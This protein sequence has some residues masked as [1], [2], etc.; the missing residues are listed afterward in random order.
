MKRLIITL[1]TTMILTGILTGPAATVHAA[2]EP[3]EIL[4][5]AGILIDA[6][7]GAVLYSKNADYQLEPASTTKMITCLLA[8]ENLQL[9]QV[10]TIDAETPFTEGSRIYL[11]EGE[12]IT[13]EHLLYALMLESA[14]DAAVALA[15]E[16]AGSVENFAVMMN[17]RAKE[18]GA[19]N[20]NFVNPNGLHLEG[21]ASTVYDLAMIAK[22]AME[23]E[24][25][26]TIVSTYRHVIP[27]TNK[28]EERYMYNTNRLLYDE[29]TK[30][31]VLGVNRPAKYEGA[32]GI[33]T[34]YTSHAQGCLVAGAQ[35]EG[36][37]LIAAVLQ[38]TDPGRFGDCIALLDYGFANFRTVQPV[39]A[40]TD[41]GEVSV[42]K[43]AVKTV[44]TIIADNGYVTLPP[45]ASESV[46]KTEIK[47]DEDIQAPITAGQKLGV[48][49]IYEGGELYGSV[50][51][52]ATGSVEAGGF[53]ILTSL[54]VADKTAGTILIVSSIVLGLV[55]LLLITYIILK[56]R[57]I[58]RRRAR[59]EKR[60]MEIA[61]E[62]QKRQKE[63]EQ[64]QW[65]YLR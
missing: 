25:F 4:A 37:E 45:E 8:L 31:P 55:L 23:N 46:I 57:Q 64:R 40:G 29:K 17:E 59:R 20:T 19:K 34:G 14:I 26:R 58:R 15:K 63:Y 22:G 62:R 7:T 48:V 61:L 10:V 51:I 2:A 13:V 16:I 44:G 33:K 5:T 24:T 6:K 32:I 65:P 49:E 27:A 11:L 21:H 52:I 30:V 54:G 9:S 3:P 39:V 60:A 1:I 53:G 56:R 35:R 41:T 28:Q 42:R 18:L 47:M 50:D 12:E 43:G 36:T 38:S